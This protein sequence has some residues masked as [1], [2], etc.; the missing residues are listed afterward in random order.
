MQIGEQNATGDIFNVKGD[1]VLEN[2][3]EV[4]SIL[5]KQNQE[6]LNSQYSISFN[7]SLEKEMLSKKL[8]NREGIVDDIK[9]NL[10]EHRQL[11]VYGEP[12]IGK[13]TLIYQLISKYDDF[14][15]ISVKGK[16]ALSVI[17]YLIN[18]LRALNKEALLEIDNLTK[19]NEIFQVELQK[20]HVSI[21][22]DDC[23]KDSDF[24]KDIIELEKF[25]TNFLF[26]SRNQTIFET[27]NIDFYPIKHF[28]EKEVQEFLTTN[29]I[30]TGQIKFNELYLASKGNPLYLFY[31]SQ[32]QISPLP[33]DV[34]NYQNTIWKNLDSSSQELIIFITI[35]FFS[36]KLIELSELCQYDS[37]LKLSD[38]IDKL[39]SL[40]KVNNGILNLFH[41]SFGEH[42]IAFLESK[43]LI[44]TYY[45]QLGDFFLTKEDYLQATYLLIDVA[46]Q[47]IDKYLLDV[48]PILF[49]IGEIEFAI[50]VLNSILLNSSKQLHHGYAHYHLCSLYRLIGKSS[51]SNKHIALALEKLKTSEEEIGK[52]LYTSALMFQAINKIEDGN[53][54]KGLEIANE[55]LL[56]INLFEKDFKASILVN[57]SKIYTDLS[58]FEKGAIACKEAFEIFEKDKHEEGML[59]SLTNL[60]T[61]LT[62]ITDYL[63]DA[64]K[65]GLRLLK[66]L[67]DK[68]EFMKEVIVLNAL[69][70][71]YR[72][73]GE[74]PK[75]LKFGNKVI[76]LCQE[77]GLK[78]KVILNLI[79]YGN[80]LRDDNQTEPALKIYNEALVYAKEY[81]LKKEEGRIYWILAG[82][83]RDK[84]QYDA[85]IDYAE[86]AIAVNKS[87]D[88]YYGVANAYNE[89]AETLIC[90]GLNIEAAKSLEE[91]AEYYLKIE[92]FAKSYQVRLSEAIKLYKN[93]GKTEDVNR[94]LN[95]IVCTTS[96]KLKHDNLSELIIDATLNSEATLANFR[97]VFESHFKENSSTNL[98]IFFLDYLAYCQGLDP[99]IGKPAFLEILD[100]IIDN[101]GVAKFSSSLLG[102]A[103]EQSRDLLDSNDLNNINQQLQKVL[104]LYSYRNL[105]EEIVIVTSIHQDVNLEIHVFNDEL[106]CIKVALMLVLFLNE[107]PNLI[108]TS[109]MKLEKLCKLWIHGYSVE[110]K[111]ALEEYIGKSSDVFS[112]LCQS[113]HMEKKDYNLHEM[114]IVSEDYS[115]FSN[116]NDIPENKV[117]MY[118]LVMSIAGIKG[119]F[120]HQDI[121]NNTQKRKEILQ[122]VAN[123]FDLTSLDMESVDSQS[124]YNINFESLEQ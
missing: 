122:S 74:Y 83:E 17:S 111:K 63:D 123:M 91:S 64:E 121:K 120:Y 79:N 65:Y 27:V 29:D 60:V 31:F 50:K 92:Y 12:G 62:Q 2:S 58:E 81:K 9:S 87:V 10:V 90:M 56:D 70:S 25:D 39:S 102:I 36:L 6:L 94:V 26:V 37:T 105:S 119:H 117:S 86:K 89:K 76:K 7:V 49:N 46:P 45:N 98:T 33:K 15:Y 97:K 85:S 77:Y 23:E 59:S 100:L 109:N 118:F 96:K 14:L 101:L 21:I 44:E 93:E 22:I 78:D 68:N 11:L 5:S 82:I 24:V 4:L 41:P 112:E 3:P 54:K 104:P 114:I 42:I 40:V 28:S 20:S 53:V 38:D 108:G 34:Q 57:L 61:C 66:L 32:M 8:I 75:A 51:E 16:P 69:T 67:E 95:K 110:M 124:V 88:F 18:K 99:K 52:K 35:P 30:N 103:I 71:I 1:L 106:P 84:S 43:G 19:A 80:V 116:L 107:N 72:Q 73:K 13:T 47:K 115:K 48:F 113:L 55:V